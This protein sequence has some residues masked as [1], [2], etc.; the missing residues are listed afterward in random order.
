M[1]LG[2]IVQAVTVIGSSMGAA[3]IWAYIELYRHDRLTQAVFVDQV[4]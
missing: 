2:L 3:I 4:T 1:V